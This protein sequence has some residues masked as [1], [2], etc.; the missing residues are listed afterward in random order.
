ME[1]VQFYFWKFV[2]FKEIDNIN[3]VRNDLTRAVR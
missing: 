2:K 1:M 3:I